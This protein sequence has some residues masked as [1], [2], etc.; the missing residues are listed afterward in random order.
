MKRIRHARLE[1]VGRVSLNV[2]DAVLHPQVTQPTVR[3]I[4]Q[5]VRVEVLRDVAYIHKCALYK[6]QP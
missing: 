4:L 5:V 1:A 6:Q 3:L 2:T